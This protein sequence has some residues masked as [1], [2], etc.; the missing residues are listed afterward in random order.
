MSRTSRISVSTQEWS[1]DIY[2]DTSVELM[3]MNDD[4]RR[5]QGLSSGAATSDLASRCGTTPTR[6]G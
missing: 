4:A 1:D 5:N 3:V 2:L 6:N